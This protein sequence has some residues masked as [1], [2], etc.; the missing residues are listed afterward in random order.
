MALAIVG[1]VQVTETLSGESA[2][3]SMLLRGFYFVPNLVVLSP[4][5]YILPKVNALLI[6]VNIIQVKGFDF[7]R[8]QK[9]R[10]LLI[11]GNV[12]GFLAYQALRFRL[13][14]VL[15]ELI[16]QFFVVAGG[17]NHQ[18]VNPPSRI[19]SRNRLGYWKVHLLEISRVQRPSHSCD[20]FMI[21]KQIRQ[22]GASCPHLTDFGFSSSS[23]FFTASSCSSLRLYSWLGLGLS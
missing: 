16:R 12:M 9:L 21:L 3:T 15:E 19:F 1:E 6:I 14:H 13:D 5:R 17:S 22:F 7:G 4:S 10:R 8:F 18:V 23:F 20:H 2:R 11:R